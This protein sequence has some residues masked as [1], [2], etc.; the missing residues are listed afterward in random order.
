MIAPS[1][2]AG[3]DDWTTVSAS[4]KA[5]KLEPGDSYRLRIESRYTSGT[6]VLVT[7]SADYDNVALRST[8]SENGGGGGNGG[9]KGKGNDGGNGGDL[10]SSELLS[11]FSN[12]QSNTATVAGGADGKGK[13]LLVRV[14]CPKKIGAAAGSR[15]RACSA[16]ASR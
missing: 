4:I 2:L 7:G 8:G 12:G 16:S 3:A 11:L 6:S 10:R 15:P 5:G 9:G 1:T 13:R 14:N